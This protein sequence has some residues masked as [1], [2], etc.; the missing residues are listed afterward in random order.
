MS[1]TI[2]KF[3]TPCPKKLNKKNEENIIYFKKPIDQSLH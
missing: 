1:I 3:I 2:A